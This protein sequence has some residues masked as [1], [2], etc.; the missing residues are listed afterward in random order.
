MITLRKY[1]GA[2]S[3][4]ICLSPTRILAFLLILL[5]SQILRGKSTNPLGIDGLQEILYLVLGIWAVCS[6]WLQQT[7]KGSVR[8]L[9]IYV[10]VLV[11]VPSLYGSMLAMLT[12]GQPPVY[13]ILE[14]RRIFAVLIYFPIRTMLD[15]KWVS[16][17]DFEKY[18]VIT[19]IICA[20]L[21]IGILLRI[22]PTIQAINT[23]EI[24]LRGERISIGSG[25]IALSIPFL[26]SSQAPFITRWRLLLLPLAIFTL[27]LIVQSRQLI[28]LSLIATLFVMR[29]PRAVLL[30][31]LLI[32][33]AYIAILS[34]PA[35]NERIMIII[36]L[37]SEAVSNNY[38][39]SS[40]RALSYAHVLESWSN[41]KWGHGSL[42]PFWK[43]GFERAI[44]GFFYLADIGI[45]GTLFRYGIPGILLYI[46]WGVLQFRLIRS[47]SDRRKRA[48]MG[49][50]FLFTLMGMPVAAPLEYRGYISGMLLGLTGYLASKSKNGDIA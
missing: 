29:G 25:W 18:V 9:D 33:A 3:A 39:T 49:A 7:S 13:G 1:A 12:Y 45:V 27:L 22:I 47:I 5:N 19:A 21:S 2:G 23:S 31:T 17:D 38:T 26:M 32:T 40:W 14:E 20:I 15:R 16:M 50:L 48:L 35:L 4:E 8:S 43:S 28:V 41:E 34:I 11:L 42:S 46:F 37:F 10:L 6:L 44:G 24:A 30:L 36:Q